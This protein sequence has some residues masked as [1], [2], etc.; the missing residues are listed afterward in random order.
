[1]RAI[2]AGLL[3]VGLAMPALAPAALAQGDV[4]RPPAPPARP[5]APAERAV[6]LLNRTDTT[7]RELYIFVPGQPLGP[8]RL[9]ADVVPAGSSYTLRLRG[10]ADC[11]QSMRVVWADESEE[12]RV[13]DVCAER[14]VVLTDEN[15]RDVELRNDT[16]AVL[17]QVF[18]FP[19][20]GQ[21]PGPDRLG[22]ATVAPNDGFRLR[23]R[24]LR[25]CQVTVRAS[26]QGL[27]VETREA[28]ICTAPTLAFGDSSVPLREV[29]VVNRS[30]VTLQVIHATPRRDNWGPDRLGQ[31]VLP[32]GQSFAMRLRSQECRVRVRAIFENRREELREE[33]DVCAGTPIVFH[34][35][36]RMALGSLY[37]RPIVGVYLSSATD[38]DWGP[39]QLTA[40]MARGGTAEIGTD[41]E[42]R[43]DLRI[44][45]DN[46]GA[47]E[48]RNFDICR[49]RA[50]TLRPGWVAET[51]E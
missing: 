46:E 5:A 24:G 16:D 48:L 43:A 28:D 41:G 23:I 14:R 12:S 30:S 7:V 49:N 51:R 21:E 3:V 4:K 38:R 45:F 31:N 37:D 32:A 42:C 20:G 50:I 39:N 40:P 19:R 10:V 13:L 9:G 15:R 36:R 17:M 29:Q 33:V 27:P 2:L 11:R 1:M 47:E 18:I 8:D 6:E 34:G 35:A 25:E 22:R 44:V 26:F